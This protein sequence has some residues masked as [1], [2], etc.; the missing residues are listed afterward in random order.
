MLE[1]RFQRL[2]LDASRINASCLREFAVP[3]YLVVALRFQLLLPVSLTL[4]CFLECRSSCSS[5]MCTFALRVAFTSAILISTACFFTMFT[6]FVISYL[7]FQYEVSVMK[8]YLASPSLRSP[9]VKGSKNQQLDG[10]GFA[11][12]LR[13]SRLFAKDILAHLLL[14]RRTC[15]LL[16]QPLHVRRT[17]L[18]GRYHA[19]T[20]KGDI[21]IS[22]VRPSASCLRP[23]CSTPLALLG[24]RML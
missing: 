9:Q 12:N 13:V 7:L 21:A 17:P 16:T 8:P 5:N 4:C 1:D 20:P 6:F 11:G 18:L 15:E 2:A 19:I 22:Q 14:I 24:K 23:Y 10:L 3:A